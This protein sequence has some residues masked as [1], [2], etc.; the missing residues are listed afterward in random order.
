MKDYQAPK[1]DGCKD[2]TK[3]VDLQLPLALNSGK[4]KI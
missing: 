4:T 3:Y 2:E 1:L